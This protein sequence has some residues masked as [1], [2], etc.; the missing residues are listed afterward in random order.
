MRTRKD[1]ALTGSL[2]AGTPSI[3]SLARGADS[4]PDAATANGGSVRARAAQLSPTV[5]PAAHSPVRAVQSYASTSFA[6]LSSPRLLTLPA[7]S[8]TSPLLMER[9]VHWR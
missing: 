7:H 4:S 2:T 3:L 5:A 6:P 9:H 8:S 1:T